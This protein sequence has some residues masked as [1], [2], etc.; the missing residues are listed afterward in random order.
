M[1]KENENVLKSGPLKMKYRL[2]YKDASG[3]ESVMTVLWGVYSHR[4]TKQMRDYRIFWGL[5][6]IKWS[7]G[8]KNE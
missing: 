4:K 2:F 8:D 3:A 5:I 6:E 1:P 7:E